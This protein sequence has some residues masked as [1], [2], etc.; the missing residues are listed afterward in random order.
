MNK[1]LE[2]FPPGKLEI[3]KLVR[4][5]KTEVDDSSHE[6]GPCLITFLDPEKD[7]WV[8]KT[9]GMSGLRRHKLLRI[10][11]EA[12]EQSISLNQE[13]VSS[14]LLGCGIRT[15]QRD[16]TLFA[17]LG[18]WVPFQH[19]S[20][21][22]AERYTYKVAVVKQYLEGTTK[23]QIASSLYHDP[24]RIAK[25]IAD[26]SR[27]TQLAQSGLSSYQIEAV[28]QLP[29]ALLEEYW[30]LFKAYNTPQLFKK[31]E[32]LHQGCQVTPNPE[33][34]EVSTHQQLRG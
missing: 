12:Y 30:A 10:T 23:A 18:V 24:D 14:D 31:L 3:S 9:Y 34:C 19:V 32:L 20:R 13:V 16:I 33:F 29:E 22:R 25:F 27:F 11:G 6:S 5:N 8:R 4:L 15:L 7:R 17:S 28:L 21:N 1:P 2:P 26:F